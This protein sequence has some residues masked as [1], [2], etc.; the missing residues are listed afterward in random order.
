MFGAAKGL[1]NSAYVTL[2]T[3]IGCGAIVNGILSL[4]KDG[5]AHEVGHFVI[6]L[7]GRLKCSCGRPGHW[8]AYCSG[9]NIPNFVRMRLQEMSSE[10][11][12]NSL[13]FKRFRGDFSNLKAADLFAS[14]KERDRVSVKLVHEIGVLNAMGFANVV[15]AYD[16]SLITV[17]GAVTLE[18]QELVLPPIKR[19]VGKYA[20][21]RIPRILVTPLGDDVVLYGAVA[22]AMRYLS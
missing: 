10:T 14:A 13:L 19:H 21:N 5:N 3:G 4:G 7:E 18:N 20:L 22:T 17:G 11:V 9:R 1:D 16:P 8:E 2:S 12:K 15:N 6:D